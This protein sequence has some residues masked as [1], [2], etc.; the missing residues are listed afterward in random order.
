MK[1]IIVFLIF[2]LT[3]QI[4]SQ[5]TSSVKYFPLQTGNVW[6]YYGTTYSGSN[7]GSW[8]NKCRVIGT[9]DTLGK[10]YYNIQSI[11]VH[12]SGNGLR[13]SCPAH[14]IKN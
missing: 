3:I 12:A 8:F 14:K 11:I 9:I 10:R 2:I 1:K 6:V 13:L 7:Y 5:D 4:F